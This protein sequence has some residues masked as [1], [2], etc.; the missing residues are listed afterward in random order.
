MSGGQKYTHQ[1]AHSVGGR[2]MNKFEFLLY[3]FLY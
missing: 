3:T 2:V 1:N